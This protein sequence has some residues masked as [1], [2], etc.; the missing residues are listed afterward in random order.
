MTVWTDAG[1]RED[2][3]QDDVIGVVVAGRDIALY[4]VGGDVFVSAGCGNCHT[5][6]AAQAHG[7]VAPN[8]DK[9]R[10]SYAQVRLQVERGGGSMPAFGGKL[11]AKQI[12][13][14]AAYVATN[15]GP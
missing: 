2:V 10:P 14:V 7:Q 1:A 4:S 12:R 6:S 5:L 11:S 13:D 15:A 8:L 3:P 9:L